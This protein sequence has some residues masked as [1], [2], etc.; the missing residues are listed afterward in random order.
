MKTLSAVS[1]LLAVAIVLTP[2]RP[3]GAVEK[4][5]MMRWGTGFFVSKSGHLLTNFHVV[6]SCRQLTVQS[7]R[8]DGTAQVVALDPAND[9]ALLATNL[10]PARIAEW[11][12]SAQDGEPVVVYGF[13]PG[14]DRTASG[15]V[16]GLAGLHDN[17]LLYS[18]AG[19][20]PGMSGSA[21]ID[22]DGRVLGI[23]VEVIGGKIGAAAASVAAAALLDAHGVAHAEGNAT[24][25][26]PISE[27]IARAKAISA[28]VTCPS[29]G[30]STDLDQSQ[31][32]GHP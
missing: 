2:D 22:R 24:K 3:A 12:Q 32:D 8:L 4:M 30:R 1:A 19:I 9:L 31:Q 10:K 14:G 15:T 20:E 13:P 23:N 18:E 16:L 25:P 29:N 11:R 28:K 26:L 6:E 27:V 7:R 21:I 5:V 17:R